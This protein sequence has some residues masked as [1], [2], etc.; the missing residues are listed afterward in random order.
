MCRFCVKYRVGGSGAHLWPAVAAASTSLSEAINGSI[1][2]IINQK[3][4]VVFALH[5]TGHR[6]WSASLSASGISFVASAL[7]P[8]GVCRQ[9]ACVYGCGLHRD[10]GT[11]F[12][13]YN[14][15]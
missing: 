7:G 3:A 5:S 15:I 1:T 10:I 13:R 9:G 14:K 12:N 11:I 2:S 6:S 4:L 8:S